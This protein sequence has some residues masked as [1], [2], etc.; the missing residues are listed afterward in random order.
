MQLW[1]TSYISAVLCVQS[2]DVSLVCSE[3]IQISLK[4]LNNAGWIAIVM[5]EIYST[6]SVETYR[7]LP[8]YWLKTRMEEKVFKWL[9]NSGKA[10][11]MRICCRTLVNVFLPQ[12][13]IDHSKASVLHCGNSGFKNNQ[14]ARCN[15]AKKFM[16]ETETH[17]W[18]QSIRQL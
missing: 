13:G 6:S 17:L 11:P 7:R 14:V 3:W 16:A 12:T 8:T 5:I 9:R 10:R 1:T 18:E 2:V 4:E 15:R